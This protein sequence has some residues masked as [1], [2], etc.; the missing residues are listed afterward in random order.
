MADSV[1]DC[2]ALAYREMAAEYRKRAEVVKG[3][4]FSV[5]MTMALAHERA[6]D[7]LSQELADGR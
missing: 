4:A 6:A 3:D 1:S 7:A 5:I 2:M